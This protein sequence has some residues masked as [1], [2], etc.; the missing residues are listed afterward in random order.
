MASGKGTVIACLVLLQYICYADFN[1]VMASTA[2]PTCCQPNHN[3]G[4]CNLS[5]QNDMVCCNSY[6]SSSCRGGEC[7]IRDGKHVCHCYC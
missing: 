1:S 7:N 5:N 6:C 4:Q 3:I 2:N